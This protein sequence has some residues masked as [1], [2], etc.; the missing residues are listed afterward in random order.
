MLLCQSVDRVSMEDHHYGLRKPTFA[1]SLPCRGAGATIT[2]Y[3][4][5]VQLGNHAGKWLFKDGH[6][7]TEAPAAE[8]AGL[9][10]LSASRIAYDVFCTF[11]A[12]HNLPTCF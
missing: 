2:F 8:R 6:Q 12:H 9:N 10:S 7:S 11:E 1:K 4:S 5:V 3:T